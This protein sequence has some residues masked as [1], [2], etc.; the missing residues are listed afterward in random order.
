MP[1]DDGTKLSVENGVISV[2]ADATLTIN[3]AD[4]AFVFGGLIKRNADVVVYDKPMDE[5]IPT[6]GDTS[7]PLLWATLIFIASAGLAINTGLRRKLREE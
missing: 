5:P 7:K 4:Q 2:P 3:G 1:K 6:T